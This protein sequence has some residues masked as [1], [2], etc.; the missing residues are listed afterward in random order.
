[1]SNSATNIIYKSQPN[2]IGPVNK[3]LT[4]NIE[5]GKDFCFV[6]MKVLKV[7]D[8]IDSG[9]RFNSVKIYMP[10]L[11]QEMPVGVGGIPQVLKGVTSLDMWAHGC[12]AS[13]QCPKSSSSWILIEG[14]PYTHLI[15]PEYLV[16]PE[17]AQMSF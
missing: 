12:A 13:H 11:L 2:E 5:K 9:A 15:H 4:L 17:A 7:N 10:S 1:M 3:F 6:F 8:W 14:G 16:N